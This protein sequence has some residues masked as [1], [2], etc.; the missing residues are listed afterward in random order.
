MMETSSEMIPLDN[1]PKGYDQ[2]MR[3]PERD[4]S[5]CLAWH[6]YDKQSGRHLFVKQ[7]RP[8]FANS[9][10]HRSAFFKEYNVGKKLNAGFFPTYHKLEDS[11]AGLFITMDYIDGES[12][13]ERMA[14]T[15][16][17]FQHKQNTIRILCQIL[18]AIDAMHQADI[19]HMDL[20][21]DNILR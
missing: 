2:T 7:L 3:L 12:L 16:H 21:P 20:K 17:Y 15:P 1:L 5:T 14:S 10:E 6:A 4:S 19:I 8:E 9:A 18:K 13:T 11:E